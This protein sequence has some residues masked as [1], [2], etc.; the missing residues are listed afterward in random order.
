MRR[1][2]GFAVLLAAVAVVPLAAN[3]ARYY[4]DGR[5]LVHEI[6]GVIP[7]RGPRIRVETDLGAVR[8][9]AAQGDEVRYSIRV[10]A[11]AAGPE[12]A[13]RLID[14]L[15]I[16]A[17]R[18]DDLIL[19]TGQTSDP[20]SL[21]GLAAEFDIAVPPGTSAVEAFTGGGDV[22]AGDL[23]GGATFV[24]R[25][26]N[27]SAGRLRGPLRAETTSGAIRVGFVGA[28]SR[29]ITGGGGVHLQEGAGDVLIRTSG[30]DVDIGRGGG[31]IEIESGGGNVRIQEAAGDVTVGTGGGRIALGRVGGRVWAATGGGGIRIGSADGGVRCETGAGAIQLKAGGGPIQA[32]T[33]VG[34]ILADLSSVRGSFPGSE[35][36]TG[37]GDIIVA[38]PGSLALTVRALLDGPGAGRI[39][40]EFPLEIS[41]RVDGL[42]RPVAFAEGDIAGGGSLLT[43]RSLGGD[44][45][46]TRAEEAGP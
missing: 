34:N 12:D 41:R 5:F 20:A 23:D 44:I 10:R 8:V 46:I 17:G 16:G 14:R 45:I 40:S 27:I 4:R 39:R 19:F 43:I 32:L 15:L 1:R 33:S 6:R 13:R 22:V 28:D 37:Q 38:I 25:A 9:Q 29:L 35:L 36:Q 21:R 26:G 42:G 31:R 18:Q 3:E 30:G 2:A 11:A 7:A 24:T